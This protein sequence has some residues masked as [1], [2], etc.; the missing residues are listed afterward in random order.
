[1]SFARDILG[2]AAREYGFDF[3]EACAKFSLKLE[4]LPVP[5]TEVSPKTIAA[6]DDMITRLL[7]ATGHSEPTPTPTPTSAATAVPRKR[8]ARLTPEEKAERVAM[9]NEEKARRKQMNAARRE[10]KKAALK[11]A[12]MARKTAKKVLKDAQQHAVQSAK[13]AQKAVKLAVKAKKQN[14]QSRRA[15]SAYIIFSNQ[16][17]ER[18][19]TESP[20]LAAK[21]VVSELARRWR[22]LSP[23]GKQPYEKAHLEAKAK[24]SAAQTSHIDTPAEDESS[25]RVVVEDDDELE[26]TVEE[27]LQDTASDD[28][29]EVERKTIDGVV[30]LVSPSTYEVF[31]RESEELIGIFCPHSQTIKSL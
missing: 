13:D 9:N 19:K 1:M 5:L 2:R 29:T 11:A 4:D 26:P 20:Q 31:D 25:V 23:A 8:N 21:E 16:N 3:E 27:Y 28:E 30:Y 14:A 15:P 18:V 7:E 6:N 10:E 12:V 22:E 24:L 17:R